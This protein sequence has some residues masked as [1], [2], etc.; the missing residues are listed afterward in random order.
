LNK[1]KPI[2]APYTGMDEKTLFERLDRIIVILQDIAIA[3]QYGDASSHTV[4]RPPPLILRIANGAAT[5]VGI[6]GVLS[7]IELIRSW[8]GG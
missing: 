8:I 5:G 2:T 6:L 4:W 7:A 3:K 1:A